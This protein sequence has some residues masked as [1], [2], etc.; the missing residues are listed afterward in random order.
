MATWQ[1]EIL[2]L[3][4]DLELNSKDVCQIIRRVEILEVPKKNKER[5]FRYNKAHLQLMSLARKKR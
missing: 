1:K 5:A 4:Y 3:G 2:R